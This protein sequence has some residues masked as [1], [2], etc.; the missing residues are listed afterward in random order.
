MKQGIEG[1]KESEADG[2]LLGNMMYNLSLFYER[3][4]RLEEAEAMMKRALAIIDEATQGLALS[5]GALGPC[6]NL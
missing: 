5:W 4:N 2:S 3:N 1:F 6:E